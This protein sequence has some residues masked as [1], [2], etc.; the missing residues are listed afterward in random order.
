MGSILKVLAFT[1]TNLVL[2]MLNIRGV[3]SYSLLVKMT[4]CWNSYWKGEKK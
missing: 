4:C 1:T 3:V 2:V